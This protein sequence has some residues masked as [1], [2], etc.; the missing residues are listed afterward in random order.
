MSMKEIK[1]IRK[2]IKKLLDFGYIFEPRKEE[3][4][5]LD[6]KQHFYLKI[7]GDLK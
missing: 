1:I 5:S 7:E 3:Y 4:R 2:Q 6:G